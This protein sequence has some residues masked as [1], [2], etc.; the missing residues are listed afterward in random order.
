M[1][2]KPLLNIPQEIVR[3][4]VGILGTGQVGGILARSFSKYL[5]NNFKD[6]KNFNPF[7]YIY[8]FSPTFARKGEFQAQGFKNFPK[9]ENELVENSGLVFICCKPDQVQEVILKTR[10]NI[11]K[12]TVMVST[13]AGV[14]KDFI[15]SLY[16]TKIRVAD[17]KLPKKDFEFKFP[18]IVR[19]MTNHLCSINEGA[20]VYSV[21][22]LCEPIDEEIIKSLF[23]DIG[24]VSKTHEKN[25]NIF[26]SLAGSAPA[27][28]YEFIESLVDGGIKNG[29][30]A[31]TAR[32]YAIQTVYAAAKFM[33]EAKDKNPNN[34]KYIVT[35]PAGTTITGLN[36]LNKHKFK[37]AVNMAVTA[38]SR[39][40][41]EIEMERMKSIEEL[42]NTEFR[43]RH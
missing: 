11:H 35:T 4:K 28:V 38:A 26:T 5:K 39:R 27:F 15:E 3:R 18:K 14:T 37:Y 21:N 20:T 30:D 25:M 36:E 22:N 42:K 24:I 34:M 23:S 43:V 6:E 2:S 33:Q 7:D 40:G 10:T 31:N 17:E 16:T 13:A 9:S 12:D 41:K 29:V 1:N 8:L 32:I 19:V